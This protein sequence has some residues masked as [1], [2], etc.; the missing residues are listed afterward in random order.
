MNHTSASIL[1][2]WLLPTRSC[3]YPGVRVSTGGHPVLIRAGRILIP[4]Q[5]YRLTTQISTHLIDT[6]I[7]IENNTETIIF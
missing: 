1:F 4:S 7:K 2:L 3:C 6:N 5:D